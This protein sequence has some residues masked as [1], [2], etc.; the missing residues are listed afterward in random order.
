MEH[1]LNST[2][3]P[4]S[5]VVSF[6]LE[7]GA[8]GRVFKVGDWV[9]VL[10]LRRVIWSSPPSPKQAQNLLAFSHRH[11]RRNLSLGFITK[12][13]GKMQ[14]VMAPWQGEV[15]VGSGPPASVDVLLMSR[16]EFL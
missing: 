9:V 8:G 1:F 15:Q 3:L 13:L 4:R 5:S 7:D 6:C 16:W 2:P 14:M 10:S 12:L 11:L